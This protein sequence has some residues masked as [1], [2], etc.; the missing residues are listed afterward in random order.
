MKL[1]SP[2]P[3]TRLPKIFVT[4]QMT[5]LEPSTCG[6]WLDH[7]TLAAS[8]C[9]CLT[10]HSAAQ[11]NKAGQQRL[12]VTAYNVCKVAFRVKKLFWLLKQCTHFVTN[13]L[14]ISTLLIT[15]ILKNT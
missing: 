4:V 10:Q 1:E 13:P 7:Q 3:S 14:C 2:A 9:A 6:R 8:A 5:V 12:C 11:T 15:V